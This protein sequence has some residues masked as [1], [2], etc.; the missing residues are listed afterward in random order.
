ML[1]R[2]GLG[3]MEDVTTLVH[4][5]SGPLE[6]FERANTAPPTDIITTTLTGRTEER[7]DSSTRDPESPLSPSISSVL[8]QTNHPQDPDQPRQGLTVILDDETKRL[9]I[10]A[11]PGTDPLA[12]PDGTYEQVTGDQPCIN[13][14]NTLSSSAEEYVITLHPDSLF[15]DNRKCVNTTNA[16]PLPTQDH[17]PTSS[18]TPFRILAPPNKTQSIS[19]LTS[20]LKNMEKLSHFLDRLQKLAFSVPAEQ[21]SQQVAM[22]CT[23]F[24]KHHVHFIELLRLIEE[25]SSLYL[26]DISAEIQRQS[27]FL[28]VLKNRSDM[29]KTLRRQIVDL[30]RTYKSGTIA[31]MREARTK[32]KE[33]PLIC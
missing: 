14:I 22:L 10:S 7:K 8:N 12:V 9:E 4:S 28:A 1:W 2:H 5:P 11:S 19:T 13:P 26:L 3:I 31:P 15:I 29:A 23:T 33:S 20:L 17:I 21:Q 16:L 32:G 18:P 30:R 24:K 25:F 27:H 6:V